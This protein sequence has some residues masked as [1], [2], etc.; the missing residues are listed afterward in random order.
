M[1]GFLTYSKSKFGNEEGGGGGS[2][3]G[4]GGSSTGTANSGKKSFLSNQY[5]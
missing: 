4:G 2:D 1:T 3:G 5:L